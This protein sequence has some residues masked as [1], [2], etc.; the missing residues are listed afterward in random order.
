VTDEIATPTFESAPFSADLL[1][2]LGFVVNKVG[3][4]INRQTERVTTPY[5]LTIKQ[6][7]LLFLLQTEGPQSQIV[8]SEKAGLDR[9][10]VMRHVDWLEKRGFVR[11][12]V[13]PAD[14]R[15]NHVVLT[16]TGAKLLSRTLTEVRKAEQTFAAV[17]SEQ[18]RVQLLSLLKRL[19]GLG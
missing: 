5:G 19:L 2:N 17:L 9:T 15:V 1:E 8:L 16:D 14:R 6:Y 4:S 7:G 10:S 18:E 11:R 12:D 3:E 13:Q